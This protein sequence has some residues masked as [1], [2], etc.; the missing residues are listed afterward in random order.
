MSVFVNQSFHGLFDD[1]GALLEDMRLDG[2]DFTNC[3]LSLTQDVKRMSSVQNVELKDCSLNGCFMG[4]TKLFDVTIA[5]LK[6]NDL[7]IIWCPYLD[8]V[9]L[10]GEIGKMKVNLY[11]DPSTWENEK[12]KPFDDYRDQF[13]ANVEWALDISEARF[14][15]LLV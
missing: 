14:G 7:F 13:Y 12:Q 1:G 6:T 4:P 9:T 8:R 11:A 2:C 15:L 3:G 5:N 10:S